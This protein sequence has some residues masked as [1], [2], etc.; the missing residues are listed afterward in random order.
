MKV[1]ILAGGR[2]TRIREVSGDKPKP[3]VEIG[4]RPIIWHIMASYARFGF[5]EFIVCLGYKGHLITDYFQNYRVQN[6]DL[7]VDLGSEKI[8]FLNDCEEDW[9]ITLV[10]TGL[11]TMTGGRI[12]RVASYIEEDNFCL[13]YGD[14]LSDV[15]IKALVNQHIRSGAKASITAVRPSGR[16]GLLTLGENNKVTSFSE[17]P[18]SEGGWINGGFFVLNKSVID[19]IEGDQT[20]W[21]REPLEQLVA[22]NELR[23]F[24]HN[25][26]WQCMDTYRDWETLNTICQTKSLPW[27]G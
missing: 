14:A 8:S 4:G 12:K 15:N 3:M 20:I 23:Y 26:F 2:G 11:N 25:D 9:K 10:Q 17:K 6:S 1:V 5:K 19:Y 13:T 7:I 24:L 22:E 16:F 21:E 18:S 27:L